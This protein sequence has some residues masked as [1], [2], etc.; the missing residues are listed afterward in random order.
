MTLEDT[1][2]WAC[3]PI[4]QASAYEVQ[5]AATWT[6]A[7]GNTKYG[8]MLDVHGKVLGGCPVE[9]RPLAERCPPAVTAAVIC[10]LARWSDAE[11]W[12]PPAC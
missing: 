6:R 9:G 11:L 7:V 2:P 10:S 1:Q 3:G 8:E 12:G 4:P 5:N